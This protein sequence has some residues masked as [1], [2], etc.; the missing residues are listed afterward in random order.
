MGSYY[1]I[2]KDKVEEMFD[3]GKEVVLEIEV[4]GVF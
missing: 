2:L 3:K 1:G 4:D